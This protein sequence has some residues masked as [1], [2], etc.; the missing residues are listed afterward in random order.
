MLRTL[1]SL[2]TWLGAT[3]IVLVALPTMTVVRLFDRDPAH[4]RTGRLF[5]WLGA[6]A[7]RLNPGWHVEITGDLPADP[8]R[9]YVVVGNHQSLGDIPII[10]RLPWEMKWVVKAELFQVPVFGWLMRL[11]G[12]IPVARGDKSSRA[13]VLVH[14]RDYLRKDCS[15]MIFPEGTR[16]RD[17]RVLR[18]TEGAFRLAIKEQVP[19]LPLAIDGT[20]DILPKS[21]WRLRDAEHIRLHVFP[22]VETAGLTA[23]DTGA[24]RERVRQTIVDQVAAW[25]GLPPEEL[26]ARLTAAGETEAAQQG[27]ETRSGTADDSR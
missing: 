11:A 13:K 1:H 12:D 24:L 27:G 18:F 4:Y 15:V 2:W 21:S 17:G 6:L 23:G 19:V 14:A 25:R 7:G 22:P 8:R 5:R 20:Q 3:V 10:S 16:S 26:D 9:P